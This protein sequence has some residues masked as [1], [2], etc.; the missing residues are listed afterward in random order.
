MRSRA[1]IPAI[2]EWLK[3]LDRTDYVPRRDYYSPDTLPEPLKGVSL[4]VIFLS[5]DRSGKPTVNFFA[6]GGFN[7]WG[8]TI[9]L[10]DMV[11][12][13]SYLGFRYDAWL[14]VEPGVYVY[15]W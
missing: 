12:P 9:G 8:A 10:E 1:D 3:T 5:A 11:I 6:G 13:E 7:H 2:R 15:A 14:L 4:G